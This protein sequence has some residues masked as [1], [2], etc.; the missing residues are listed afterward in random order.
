MCIPA[1][2]DVAL[3]GARQSA[4]LWTVGSADIASNLVHGG[5]VT[6]GCRRKSRLDHI[7]FEARELVRDSEFLLEHHR[8]PGRLLA[9]AERG[10]EDLH[11]TVVRTK[12]AS[13][14][15]LPASRPP[16]SR[17]RLPVSRRHA[18]AAPGTISLAF[19]NV[20]IRRSDRP[21]SSMR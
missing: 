8:A 16:A 15:P 21:T 10:V 17:P 6:F 11:T 9:V 18:L 4:D 19:T 5:P 20:I 13:R 3:V 1:A 14:F 12:L 7:D 2:V